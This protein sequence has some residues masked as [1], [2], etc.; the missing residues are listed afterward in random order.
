M[1]RS[2]DNKVTW[3]TS[4]AFPYSYT[5][6]G[7]GAWGSVLRIWPTS[8]LAIEGYSSSFTSTDGITPTL[9]LQNMLG[10][11]VALNIP[12][13]RVGI[14]TATPNNLIQVAGFKEAGHPS[15]GT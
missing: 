8:G 14:G 7:P 6:G 12:Q 10:N 13:G 15:A 5:G 9:T 11:G 3:N 4:F 1:V 2:G